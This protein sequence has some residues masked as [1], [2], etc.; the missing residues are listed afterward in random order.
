MTQPPRMIIVGDIHLADRAPSSR[1]D[2]YREDILT[3]LEWIVAFTN[4][5]EAEV[6]LL[7][8]DVFHIKRP[9]RNSH[10]LVQ[11]T[12]DILGQSTKPVRIEIGN[13]DLTADRLDSI[14]SQPLGTLALHPNVE[15]LDG[16]CDIPGLYGVPYFDPNPENYRAVVERYYSDG[17]PDKFP[18]VAAHEA[19]FPRKEEPI[20]DYIAAED[21]AE[22]FGN[23]WTAYGHIHSRMRAGAFYQAGGSWFCNNGA[24][25]RGSLHEETIHRKLAITVFDP[26]NTSEPFTSVPIPFR[27]PEEVFDLDSVEVLKERSNSADEFLQSLGS[28]ELQYL[29]VE[30]ILEQARSTEGLHKRALNELEDIIQSVTTN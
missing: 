23:K 7:L 22:A 9:D 3:K 8:G 18:F 21:W 27:K 15:L 24:I 16:A 28:T 17:G 13:H 14:P 26:D 1:K 12:A 29:T 2:T 25:S 11:R 6:L 19:I 5:S 20:Y 4:Q 30:G 10:Y